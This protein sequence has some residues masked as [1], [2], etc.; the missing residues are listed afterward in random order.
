MNFS[1]TPITSI[2]IIGTVNGNWDTDTD[3]TFNK[4]SGAWECMATLNA[5]EMKF[6]ANHDWTWNWGGTDL[7]NFTQGGANYNLAE[8]GTYFIQLFA[9]CDTKAYAVITKQ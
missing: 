3:M 7:S 8:G 5:G 1:L 2:S 9:R 6:R 4:A